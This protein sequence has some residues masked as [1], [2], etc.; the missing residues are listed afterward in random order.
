MYHAAVVSMTNDGK[1]SANGL[2]LLNDRPT[3]ITH[4]RLTFMY[5]RT[6]SKNTSNNQALA[7]AVSAGLYTPIHPEAIAWSRT[8]IVSLYSKAVMN[9]R[10]PRGTDWGHYSLNDTVCIISVDGMDDDFRLLC[11]CEAWVLYGPP[12]HPG[13]KV[14][15]LP[16]LT[17]L[18]RSRM[19][20]RASDGGPLQSVAPQHSP[21]K[22]PPSTQLIPETMDSPGGSDS[23]M[24]VVQFV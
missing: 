22:E 5:E 19:A 18:P 14:G 15:D 17:P 23:S 4:L 7:V 11:N 20:I 21:S 16:E 1:I 24:S 13:V 12:T 6:A 2:N 3:K 9:I 10:A 8:A